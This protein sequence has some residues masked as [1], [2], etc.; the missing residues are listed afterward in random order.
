MSKGVS[1]KEEDFLRLLAANVHVGTIN[2]NFDMKRYVDHRNAAGVHI[3]NI[4][5]T[6]QK[7][8][9]AARAIVTVERPE[10]VIVVCARPYGQRAV[11]KYSHYTGALSTSTS[12]WTPGTLTNQMTKKFQE[13]RLLIVADPRSDKQALVEASYV[14][15]PT[16]ALCDT[17]SPLQNVDI[18]IPCNNRST[19]SISMIFW[20]LAREVLI[21]RGK[22]GKTQDWDVMVDLFFFK[23]VDETAALPENEGK[24]EEERAEKKGDKKWDTNEGEQA[25]TSWD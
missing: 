6:W 22:L 4:E 14:N 7:I 23:K 3:I 18:A 15:I 11:I 20:L 21:L 25:G 12:R 24:D 5:H 10:D 19:E 9:L 16:I 1:R 2:L 17:D 8:K 13:P